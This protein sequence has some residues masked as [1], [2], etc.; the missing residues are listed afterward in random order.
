MAYWGLFW[1]D[2]GLGTRAGGYI[3]SYSRGLKRKLLIAAT[4]IGDP[5]ILLFDD[6]TRDL[7][8]ITKSHFW[9]IIRY[10]SSECGRVVVIA[11]SS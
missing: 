11:A 1:F 6:P 10:L 4:L 9:K 7:N 5:P 8:P 2:S 3:E